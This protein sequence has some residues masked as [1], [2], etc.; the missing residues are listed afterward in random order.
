[1]R[2]GGR[3]TERREGERKYRESKTKRLTVREK[4]RGRKISKEHKGKDG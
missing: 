4:E 1:M 3:E 2:G